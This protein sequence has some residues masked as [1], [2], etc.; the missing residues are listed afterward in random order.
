MNGEIVK[1]KYK[2]IEGIKYVVKKLLNQQ[3][4]VDV[5][6]WLNRNIVSISQETKKYEKERKHLIITY[7]IKDK[8]GQYSI[9]PNN[10]KFKEFMEREIEVMIRKIPIVKLEKANLNQAEYKQIEFMLCDEESKIILA[11]GEI[12]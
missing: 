5:Q 9:N 4:P 10:E 8:D 1:V 12:R 2:V 7:G 3:L 6:Y 11:N